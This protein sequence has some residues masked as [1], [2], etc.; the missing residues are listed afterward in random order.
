MTEAEWRRCKDPRPMMT[1]LS[2]KVS[3][4]K[5]RLYAVAACRGT[6]RKVG[7]EVSSSYAVAEEYADGVASLEQ[8]HKRWRGSG[9]S[10]LG[11]PERAADWAWELTKTR[12]A[13]QQ[14]RRA[15]LIRCIFADPFRTAPSMA[16]AWLTPT[17]VSLAQAAY[18]ERLLPWHDLDPLRLTVLADALEEAGGAAEPIAHLRSSGP[19]ARGCWVIDLIL[20]KE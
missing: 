14:V 12:S 17:V 9:D 18:D 20:G 13:V 11:W 6:W 10:D 2:G 8:L 16:S 3:E 7:A 1:F 19:H 4:R 5:L 15:N